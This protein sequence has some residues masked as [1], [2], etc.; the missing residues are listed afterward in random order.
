M[1]DM[2]FRRPK[3][4]EEERALLDE[5]TPKAT[6]YNTRWALKVFRDWQASRANK[7]VEFDKD[8]ELDQA[9]LWKVQDLTCRVE[10]MSTDSLN[11]WLSK[12]ISEVAKQNGERYPSKTLYLLICGINRYLTEV[13][14]ENSFNIL[15]KS[16]RR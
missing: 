2:R 12:F 14:G 4:F 5:T 9:V 11:F 8:H 7:N 13:H 16:E 15:A 10:E 3:T 6:H 1:S